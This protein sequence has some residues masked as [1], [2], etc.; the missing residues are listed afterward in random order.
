[1]KEV[2]A[3]KVHLEV[4][5]MLTTLMHVT[6]PYIP[7]KSNSLYAAVSRELRRKVRIVDARVSRL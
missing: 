5:N 2:S 6:P 4:E 3:D 1:M 7:F